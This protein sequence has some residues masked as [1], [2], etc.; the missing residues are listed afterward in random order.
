MPV[1]DR[2]EDAPDPTSLREVIDRAVVR[3]G[4]ASTRELSRIAR[5]DGHTIAPTTISELQR[6]TYHS[7]PKRG[8][9]QALAHLAG[10]PYRVVREAAGMGPVLPSFA[11][12]VGRIEGVDR[13]TGPERAALKGLIRVMA[14]G[15]GGEADVVDEPVPT[16]PPTAVPFRDLN[17]PVERRRR[18]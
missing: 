6:G 1:E 13:L 17:G 8:T 5:A 3:H 18:K 7:R 15:R 10:L 16:P 4:G 2:P 12:E 11:E 9:L 14:A